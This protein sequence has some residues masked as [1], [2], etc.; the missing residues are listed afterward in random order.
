[1]RNFTVEKIKL[2]DIKDYSI[3]D[4]A[5]KMKVTILVSHSLVHPYVDE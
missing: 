3:T 5:L 2:L 4:F 1:M